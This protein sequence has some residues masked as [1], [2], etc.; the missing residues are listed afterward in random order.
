MPF[1]IIT[2]SVNI[3]VYI[4]PIKLLFF[5]SNVFSIVVQTSGHIPSCQQAVASEPAWDDA[6]LAWETQGL[7][8][9]VQSEA[10]LIWFPAVSH[11]Q[12]KP[13]PGIS[14]L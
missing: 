5:F 1:F 2:F 3:Q 10:T 6:S 13:E 8:C 4:F 14:P 9:A 7:Y 12:D 11:T